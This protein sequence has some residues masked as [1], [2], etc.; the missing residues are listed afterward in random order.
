M[1]AQLIEGYQ[2]DFDIDLRRGHEGERLVLDFLYG[3]VAVEVKDDFRAADTG[4]I[5]IESECLR[6]DGWQAS[7]I[8]ATKADYW[9]IVLGETVVLGIPTH[10]VRL[11]YERA[12][13]P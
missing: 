2:P 8:L 5:Y 12:L 10:V 7:G 1:K 3:F 6:R 13:D 4:R 11:C 9:A